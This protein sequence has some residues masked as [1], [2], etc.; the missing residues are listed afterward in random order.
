MTALHLSVGHK[1]THKITRIPSSDWCAKS[2]TQSPMCKVF[3]RNNWELQHNYSS[4]AYITTTSINY[5]AGKNYFK[6]REKKK[7]E[8]K[9]VGNR[10]STISKKSRSSSTNSLV[11]LRGHLGAERCC[12]WTYTRCSSE[13]QQQRQ[14]QSSFSLL[15]WTMGVTCS[16]K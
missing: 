8:K 6:K 10:S 2:E 4:S 15:A 3:N 1:I 12:K 11:K 14:Q 9:R 13:H 16:S 5:N 7:K